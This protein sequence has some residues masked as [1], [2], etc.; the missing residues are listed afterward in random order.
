MASLTR[1]SVIS[2]AVGVGYLWFHQ[3]AF[4]LM[5]LGA[6]EFA[7]AALIG[8]ALAFGVETL[9]KRFQKPPPAPAPEKQP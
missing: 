3:Q 4:P 9:I 7:T 1:A 8:A 6:A 2:L 5:E